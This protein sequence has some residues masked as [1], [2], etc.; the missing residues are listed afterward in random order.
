MKRFS[1]LVVMA[2]VL[3]S[4]TAAAGWI[5][6]YGGEEADGGYCVQQTSDGGYIITGFTRSFGAEKNNL[7]LLKTDA[8]GDTLWTRIYGGEEHDVGRVVHQTADGGYIILGVT[9]SFGLEKPISWLLKTDSFGDTLWT[10]TYEGGYWIEPITGGNYIIA[11][12]K[13]SEVCLIK[14]DSLGEVIW[15]RTYKGEGY[16]YEMSS[17]VKQTSDG[18]YIITGATSEFDLF[19]VKTDSIGDI[20]WESTCVAEGLDRGIY[21]EE[22]DD[23]GYIIAGSTEI[24]PFHMCIC[25][26]RANASGEILYTR[27]WE[28]MFPAELKPLV[29]TEDGGYV[30][31]GYSPILMK[32]DAEWSTLWTN[33]YGMGYLWWVEQISDSGYIMA[34][35]TYYSDTED[36]DLWLIKTDSL[37]YV[38]AA[39]EE[40]VIET[41]GWKLVTSIGP[42]IVLRYTDQPQGFHAQVF[43]VTGRKV[44][45]VH[46][47]G[48]SGTITWPVTHHD[49]SPGVYFFRLECGA[50]HKT[51]KVILIR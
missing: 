18:G 24:E 23:G 50:V 43:D 31:A 22:M 32:I 47:T 33:T 11:G 6:T 49:F 25:L 10:R 3:V 15:E 37:G 2:A 38:D 39:I 29:A 46:A 5:R 16:E 17:C 44:D 35:S 21:V 12:A 26:L 14:I 19:L 40:P 7:W 9:C 28:E 34:G 51:Q 8:E 36:Y 13:S 41:W 27:H 1:L 4:T 30:L 20:L 42:Q 48:A 45:E